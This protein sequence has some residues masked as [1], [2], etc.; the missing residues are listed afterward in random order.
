MAVGP[1]FWVLVPPKRG[2][3]VWFLCLST[4]GHDVTKYGVCVG[5]PILPAGG[6][7]W[8]AVT[9]SVMFVTF[10]G[11]G[12]ARFRTRAAATTSP[13]LGRVRTWLAGPLGC[14]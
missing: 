14:R 9:S 5:L 10:E 3:E 8:F 12:I 11:C 4:S 13:A 1:L 2:Y 7:A 6:W